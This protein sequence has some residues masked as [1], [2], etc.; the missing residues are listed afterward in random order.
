MSEKL[1]EA[2]SNSP[3]ISA[4]IIEPTLIFLENNVR[5][6]LENTWFDVWIASPLKEYY[7]TAKRRD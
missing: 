5:K 7:I 3:P 4:H 2:A 1:K 6:P